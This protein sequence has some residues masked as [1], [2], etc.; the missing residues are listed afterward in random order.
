MKRKD[1]FAKHMNEMNITLESA[2]AAF[3]RHLVNGDVSG[4]VILDAIASIVEMYKKEYLIKASILEDITLTMKPEVLMTYTIVW[5][6]QP[7]LD[8]TRL[9]VLKKQVEVDATLG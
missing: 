9:Q 1:R 4:M 5:S 6:T 8:Q 7:E 2:Q 3:N